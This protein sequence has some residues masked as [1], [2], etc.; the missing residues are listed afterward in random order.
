MALDDYPDALPCIPYISERIA[1]E[2][3]QVGKLAGLY[4]AELIL[5]SQEL[6]TIRR[7]SSQRLIATV[8]G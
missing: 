8:A 2:Q 5:L 7:T 6:G 1:L 3:D 4:G